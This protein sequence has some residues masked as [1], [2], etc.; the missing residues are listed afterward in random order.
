MARG[1]QALIC[2]SLQKIPRRHTEENENPVLPGGELV[3]TLIAVSGGF[4]VGE[5][6]EIFLH[7]LQY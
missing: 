4:R 3:T 2:T 5:G 7:H 1:E 6:T